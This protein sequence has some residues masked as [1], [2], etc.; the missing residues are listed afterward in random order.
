MYID[1]EYNQIK[2]IIQEYNYKTDKVYFDSY[3]HWENFGYP[4]EYS[5]GFFINEAYSFAERA[6]TETPKTDQFKF[7][8]MMN[9]A[10]PHR[11]LTSAWVCH[12]I[13]DTESFSYTQSWEADDLNLN[14]KLGDLV[15]NSTCP[16]LTNFLPRNFISNLGQTPRNYLGD[17]NDRIV[18]M[19]N[20]FLCNNFSQ[21]TFSL[22]SEPE[23][24]EKAGNI[25]EKYLMAL[26]G[27]CMPI[28]CSG[29]KMPYTLALAGFD[30]F[31]DIINHDYQYLD[32]PSERILSALELNK[33]LI[34]NGNIK[35]SD[36]ANRHKKNLRLV[37]TDL[38]EFV[39]QWY[40]AQYKDC[41]SICPPL[42]E[43]II[44][45]SKTDK[46]FKFNFFKR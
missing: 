11:L 16:N 4:A 2:T 14:I 29:Y 10:R 3:T 15:R 22:V 39:K 41:N 28:F 32:N 7:V 27:H 42:S 18:D 46:D 21:S 36:Y 31:D 9:N 40:P 1:Q 6:Y 20:Q 44:Q 17:T 43:L 5:P 33:D 37:T 25:T 19:W 24:W 23:F 35:K 26:Y 30:V 12:N 45:N 38:D 8:A 34:I 13:L